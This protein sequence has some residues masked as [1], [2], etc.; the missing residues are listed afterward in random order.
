[1]V[2]E[3]LYT[4]ND[5]YEQ[6]VGAKWENLVYARTGEGFGAYVHPQG[7]NSST[8]YKPKDL[9]YIYKYNKIDPSKY[10]VGNVYWTVVF[11]K[12]N[13]NKNNFPKIRIYSG[14]K[15]NNTFIREITSFTKLKNI[16]EYDNHTL[17]FKLG[18]LT[19]DQLKS[20]IVKV[21]WDKTKSTEASE[22]SI[23][24]A[25]LS[26][27]YLPLKPKFTIYSEPPI[28]TITNNDEFLWRITAKNTGDGGT[29][30]T[31]IKL[32]TGV[33]ILSSNK[34]GAFNP[35][36]KKW[37]FTLGRGKSD[38]LQLRLKFSY[39]GQYN[40]VATN[41]GNYAVNK[42]VKSIVNVEQYYP[43]PS[44]ELITYSYEKC[45]AF[46]DGYFDVN[47][48]GVYN[49][50]EVHCYDITIPQGLRV[51][52]PLKTTMIDLGMNTN[53]DSFVTEG[54]TSD[55]RICLK[56]DDVMSNFEAHIRIPF[57][58]VGGEDDYT[59]TTHSLDSGKDYDGLIHILEPRGMIV[60][61]SSALSKDKRY[62]HNSVNIGSPQVWTVRAKA[63]KHNYFDE[64]KDTMS[65]DIEKMIAYIGVIPL[66]RCHKADVTADSKNSLI[67][68]RYLNRAYYGKK[69]DY[70]EDIKMTLRM[71]WQDV[72]TL[73]G[74]CEMDKPIPIDTIP[75]RPDGDPL[76]H[77]GWA[78]IYEVTNIKKI[79]DLYYEC[80]VGVKYLTHKLLTKFGIVETGKITSNA[81]K[82]YLAL[83]HDYTDDILDIF[84]P[85][86]WQNFTS[87]EDVNGDMV[88]SYELDAPSSFTLNNVTD[89]N[90]YSNW[91]IIFRNHTPTLYSE[92]FDGN[93]EM[94]LRLLNKDN[95]E[96]L[97]EHTYNNFKHYDFDNAI[98]VNSA[99]VTS[100]YKNGNAYETLNFDKIGLGYDNFSPII[101]DWKT[102]THFNTMEDVVIEDLDDE[103][104]VFLL[105]DENKGIPNQVVNISVI[106]EDGFKNNFNVITDLYGRLIFNVYWGN[107][108]YTLTVTY[109]ETEDYRGCTYTTNMKVNMEYAEYH[110]EYPQTSSFI[111]NNG[112]YVCQILD[113]NDDPVS[114]VL[115]YYS[116]KT[117]DG[118]YGHEET[119]TS[120]SNGNITIPIRRE[121]GSQMIKV[122]FKG[123]TVGGT[124]YQPCQFEEQINV[125]NENKEL[126][127]EADD[128]T[129]IQ[130]DNEKVY[131]VIVKDEMTGS[132][133]NGLPIDLYFY[134]SEETYKCSDVTDEYGVAKAPTYLKGGAWRVDVDFKGNEIYNPINITKDIKIAN[135][136]QEE[137]Y[138]NAS[139]G[140]F[141][142]DKLLSGEQE[143]FS[144]HLYS[145]DGVGVPVEPVNVQIYD[146]TGD[147][148]YVD[149]V[150]NSDEN[151]KV[152]VPFISHSENVYVLMEYKGSVYFKP[153]NAETYI[154]FEDVGTKNS[155]TLSKVTSSGED[156]IQLK[157]NNV[158][159]NSWISDYTV[160]HSIDNER[161]TTDQPFI[162]KLIVEDQIIDH[163]ALPSGT[164]KVTVFKKGDDTKYSICRTFTIT[165]VTDGRPR[166]NYWCGF[167]D[168]KDV[169]T[170]VTYEIL[171][172]SETKYVDDFAHIRFYLN[173]WIPND[174]VAKVYNGGTTLATSTTKETFVDG[175]RITYFDIYCK[176]KNW[177]KYYIRF[178][179]S[180]VLKPLTYDVSFNLSTSS[181][182]SV[183]VTQEGFAYNNE[184]QQ[185]INISITHDD[186]IITYNKGY[187]IIKMLNLETNEELYF[188]S[189]IK[190]N[191][192]PSY[193]AFPLTKSLKQSGNNWQME[194]F[195]N[196]NEDYQCGYYST[197]GRIENESV[198]NIS[199]I[200][201]FST[202][203]AYIQ[204]E[205]HILFN[206][207]Y[208]NSISFQNIYVYEE[209]VPNYDKVNTFMKQEFSHSNYYNFTFK[210]MMI[211]Y[212]WDTY[213]S[214]VFGHNPTL[215]TKDGLYI[216]NRG[217]ATQ[218]VLYNDG[219]VIDEIWLYNVRW[220]DPHNMKVVRNGQTFSF[221][222]D[223]DKVYE[224]DLIM[225]NTIGAYR[226]NETG[227]KQDVEFQAFN[228]KLEPY[229][230]SDITP[231]VSEYDGTVF[232]SNWHLELR[233]DH[234][235]FV[236]YGMLPQG[237]VGGGLV[238]L[239]DVPL[240]KDIDWDLEIGIT[241]NNARY[242]RLNK[243]T[244][245]I[246]ARLY[247]DVSTSESTLEYSELLCSPTPV[248]N[249]KTVFTRKSDEGTLYYVKPLY[250]VSDELGKVMQKPQYMCNPYIQ[251]KGGVECYTETGISL[252]SLENQ[253]SP[254]YIGNDLVR[255]EFHRRSGYIVISRYDDAT[256]SWYSAN[257]LKLSE[258]LKL[259]LNEYNDDYAKVSF[260][261]TT[262]EFYRG[263]PFIV[264]KH[265]NT[266][267]R[268]LKLVDR[269]YCETIN[270]EQ[271]MGFIEEHN[272]MMSTFAPQTSIQK[273]KQ[274]MHIGENIRVDNFALYDVASN[275]N[276]IPLE[277]NASMTTTVIDNDNA[278]AINKNF[279]GRLA[280]NFPSSSQYLKKPSNQFSLYIGNIDVGNETSITIKA[281]GFDENGAIHLDN[282]L[283]YGIWES[284]QTFTV[285]S[286]T[287]EIRATFDCIDQVK[288]IDFVIIFNTNAQSTI[289]MN[290][291]MCHDG[292]SE[293]N[294][295]VDTSIRNAN[296]VQ[297]TFDETYYAN[298]YNED[299]PVGLCIIRPNQN[300]L[301]LRN[302][303][304][305]DETVL[306]PY[307]KKANEWDK[308]NQ[309]F[310]EYLN[311]NR[312]IIDIDWEEF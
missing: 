47:I 222:I 105:D 226:N 16:L 173:V 180:L 128:L 266:D 249:A 126:I 184:T 310:L 144:F 50:E 196:D 77:R 110:F 25:R 273:F 65:I 134:S 245:E 170:E 218:L 284:S 106:G 295:N 93:W 64:K 256:D 6:G 182:E 39:I 131:S 10:K 157:I 114:N 96:P 300:P 145:G 116:F 89:V 26:I 214:F 283:Q 185:E 228:F 48:Y 202:E 155:Q 280:L 246:Q 109:N 27:N 146:G 211:D 156:S 162:N 271:S 293:P 30:Q 74:L 115:V 84:R 98:A 235:N 194:I 223:E 147:E 190:D 149:T 302:I 165:T 56:V 166:F 129:L 54:I 53:V 262:W 122:N 32:P 28:A 101:E 127:V 160:V 308:P 296:K 250:Q 186:D 172:S 258:N 63:S 141:N 136:K 83:V 139:N 57:H 58:N 99:D 41:D 263:R 36:T 152:T 210:L 234:L 264:V 278:L 29:G 291:L 303:S 289:I 107:G 55:N 164:H 269:V 279:S 124:V 275:G 260:G 66:S 187:Y 204:L 267:I 1:M 85:S 305:S 252:F 215:E 220:Y 15:G 125:Y 304:A 217:E 153:C 227:E 81:I 78:E 104:E 195:V 138:I 61:G 259:Q 255:A 282:N 100:T 257:I 265:P 311:A 247:E 92:D 197:V 34:T 117:L 20:L 205:E 299:S 103:F 168:I 135:F 68:N 42:Q 270:N 4:C 230:V 24:R 229:V 150:L 225:Y 108:E 37:T 201:I 243:L 189:Y 118:S 71:S 52:Y 236:D 60:V 21:V 43:S 244:G 95:G 290:Q 191:R 169:D 69:G 240:P 306:A 198:V 286:G 241:Y 161:L 207:T 35:S 163:D 46:E 140:V 59:V 312:Q 281:R 5:L 200:P 233:E 287:T 86:Y 274:E 120:D 49:G 3:T 8:E 192:T 112:N 251:Y 87:L 14:V 219:T 277:H 123:Q 238:L 19:V 248:P 44:G 203:E 174:T 73:Q 224:T 62:V 167:Q 193:I 288:Y 18:D 158:T 137:T 176:L 232:G 70:S 151:G 199:T 239:N 13:L 212:N 51:E 119:A 188:Y 285:N 94:S 261:G 213:T 181:K 133:V 178:E 183:T 113:E 208:Y 301:T 40:L 38:V 90:K 154:S 276:L 148:L 102:A 132:V 216:V 97:F 2:H 254:V 45:F 7:K 142:E 88:G 298:L 12:Y 297:I 76:N 253:Y 292:D 294:W 80:D 206:A 121:N 175:K 17:Q 67:E 33:T 309:V 237:A 159:Q 31:T 79:N 231:I 22:I 268:I 143:Y 209:E 171:D 177:Q 221:F 111:G 82:H 307:M 75:T 91:D 9:C 72:A 23:N 11:R 179:D 272:T 242:D 130:G